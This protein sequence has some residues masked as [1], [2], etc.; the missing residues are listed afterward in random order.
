MRIRTADT[1]KKRMAAAVKHELK[2]RGMTQARLG[3]L[4]G[5]AVTHVNNILNGKEKGV[6]VQRLLDMTNALGLEVDVE[7]RK[8]KR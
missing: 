2:A 8:G 1:L 3:E 6:S 7:I 4:V 5:V